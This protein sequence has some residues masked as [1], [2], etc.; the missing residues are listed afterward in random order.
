MTPCWDVTYR[1]NSYGAR[2]RERGRASSGLRRHVVLGD[3][4]VEGY[5]T[6]DGVR[7]TDRLEAETGEEF[8][9]F[10]TGGRFGT[11]QELMLYRSMAVSFEHD[12]VLLF[13][14]PLN[15]FIDNDARQNDAARYRPYLRRTE[16]GDQIYY[17]TRFDSR[18]LD[19][20]GAPTRALNWLSNAV[21]LVDFSR[22]VYERRQPDAH[23]GPWLSYRGY[24]AADLDVM[25]AALRDL[26]AAA[27]A[28][29]VHVFMIPAQIDLDDY[30]AASPYALPRQLRDAVSSQGNVGVEDL[31]PDFI[32]YAA[33]HQVR[34]SQFFQA[35][36]AHWSLLG[37]AVAADAVA[38]HLSLAA[39]R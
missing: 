30:K 20:I 6:A 9:N 7:M 37:N 26:G 21:D 10:G 17:T 4:F 36:D 11:V 1:A 8:L 23:A 33:A 18:D 39:S 38:R 35:C 22:R 15:D 24:A 3:S 28:R 14:L 16:H 31:L 2:D 19:F 32:A 12:D 29:R 34:M 27:G 5:G 25:A 13:V